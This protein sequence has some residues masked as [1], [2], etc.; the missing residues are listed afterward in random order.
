MQSVSSDCVVHNVVLT[1]RK[2][3]CVVVGKVTL[4]D[5]GSWVVEHSLC[6]KLRL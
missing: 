3:A 2:S 1:I 5:R 4:A 6:H